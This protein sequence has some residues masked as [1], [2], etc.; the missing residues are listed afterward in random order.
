M[1]YPARY[2]DTVSVRPAEREDPLDPQ[3]ILDQLPADE[4]GYF[5]DQYREAVDNARDP[6]GWKQLRPGAPLPSAAPLPSRPT[7]QPAR[8]GRQLR[9]PRGNPP[10]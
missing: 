6:V 4:R 9:H 5:L 8:T 10:A 3:R 1:S 2:D 7:G